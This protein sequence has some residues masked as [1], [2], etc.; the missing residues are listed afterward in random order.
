MGS[1]TV[2]RPAVAGTFYAGQEKSLRAQIESSFTHRLGP[3][4]VPKVN[5]EGARQI[6]GIVCPHAGYVYSGPVAA[7]AYASLAHDGRP[8]VV[9]LI[10]PNH[11][12]YGADIAIDSTQYWQTP[13]GLAPVD[14]QMA[15]DIQSKAPAVEIDPVAHLYEHSLEVQLPFLQYVYGESI[16]IVPILMASQD[17]NLSAELGRAIASAGRNANLVIIASTDLT[18]YETQEKAVR[19]D[20]LI[21]EAITRIAPADLLRI[22]SKQHITMC[23]PGPVAAMLVAAQVLGATHATILR[24]ATS[25]DV[26]GDYSQ[27]VGYTAAQVTR[28][29]RR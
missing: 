15:L 24:Y 20:Q 26:S 22:V 5:D 1:A 13:L 4:D 10:G 18:H 7:H 6:I 28:T 19:D 29:E 9:V 25:G 27:I 11:R 23:G 14:T 3:G 16:R 12:R 17:F 2:R 21:L 8:D